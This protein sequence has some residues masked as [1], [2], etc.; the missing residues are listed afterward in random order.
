MK[1]LLVA[2]L[3]T[4]PVA[5]NGQLGEK[6]SEGYI[7][8]RFGQRFNGFLR[9]EPGDGKKTIVGYF[10]GVEKR[11]KGGLRTILSQIV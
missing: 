9:L 1:N 7:V 8:D 6:F 11:Q 5:V 10:Q 3:L 4:I 2:I